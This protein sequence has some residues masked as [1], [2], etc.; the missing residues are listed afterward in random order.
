MT[1]PSFVHLPVL[2]GLLAG[3]LT[4]CGSATDGGEVTAA[5]PVIPVSSI[6]VERTDAARLREEFA[7]I[8]TPARSS[9][10]GFEA[11]G[12]VA[13]L[14]VDVGDRVSAGEELARLDLRALDAQIA[15]SRAQIREA[16]AARDLAA[17]TLQR[18]QTLLDRGH[19]APQ[20]VD[21]VAANV[22]AA[23][24]RRDAALASLNALL[25]RR[26]LSIL[27]APFDGV[28]T[29]RLLDEGAIAAPGQ[30]VVQL[31]EADRLELRVGLPLEEARN[32]QP[33]RDYTLIAEGRQVRATLRATTDVVEARSQTVTSI[34]EIPGD[35]GVASGAVARVVLDSTIAEEGYWVPFGALSEGR[36]GLWTVMHLTPTDT[37]D[38]LVDKRLVDVIFTDG[39]RVFVRGALEDGD[40]II[41]AGIDRVVSGQRVRLA[42]ED[43]VAQ[44]GLADSG[45]R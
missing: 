40:R 35:A 4:A 39:E 33:G 11:G 3:G 22:D 17:V 43:M 20:R 32:L 24:A 10:L 16:E 19:V 7:G 6:V 8:V 15:A 12:A 31:V 38:F 41:D 34:F 45:T 44:R 27:T 23:V 28:V 13:S 29:A 9:A 1:R 2:I 18:Q 36:R 42:E 21:E 25:A 14:S 30:T 5:R 37:G 26:A